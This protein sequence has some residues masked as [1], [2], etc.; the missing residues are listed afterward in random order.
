MNSKRARDYMVG[1]LIDM[2]ENST[3]D[4][5][6]GVVSVN[7]LKACAVK[8]NRIERMKTVFKTHRLSFNLDTSFSNYK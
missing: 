5:D 6:N 4:N 1:Y 2:H 8:A 7:E 3:H